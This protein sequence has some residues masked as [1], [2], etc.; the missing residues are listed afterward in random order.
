MFSGCRWRLPGLEQLNEC[1]RGVSMRKPSEPIAE[2]IAEF[3]AAHLL[4]AE[5]GPPD[6]D[7]ALD[8][9]NPAPPLCYVLSM[10]CPACGGS[11]V[12]RL[13]AADAIAEVKRM[14]GAPVED[15]LAETDPE[16]FARRVEA[17]YD[18]ETEQA[19]LMRYVEAETR[20][21]H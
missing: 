8:E 5:A 14:T 12:V 21:G 3:S 19:R 9:S 1:L 6:T 17:S 11:A 7:L 4:C 18:A 13:P 15:Q 10:R 16:E 20:R 2:A